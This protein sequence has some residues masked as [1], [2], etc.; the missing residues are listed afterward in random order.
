MAVTAGR[1]AIAEVEELVPAG[2]LDPECI[3]TPGVFVNR[4]VV[5][6]RE[7]RIER[8]TVRKA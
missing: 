6:A 1:I 5:A 4:I 3:H 2:A 7:K 8:R